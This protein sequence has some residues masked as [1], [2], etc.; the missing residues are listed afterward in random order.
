MGKDL[1]SGIE[2][3]EINK[4]WENTKE[5]IKTSGTDSLCLHQMEQH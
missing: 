3:E 2:Y 1:I 4:T 5:N